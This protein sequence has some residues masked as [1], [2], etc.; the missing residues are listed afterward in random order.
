MY[1][2]MGLDDTDIRNRI[3]SIYPN[4]SN[5]EL[6]ILKRSNVIEYKSIQIMSS[7]G[8]IITE[9][10]QLTELNSSNLLKYDIL[11]IQGWNL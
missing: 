6:N 2:Y 10:N 3:C 11:Q 5:G 7:D 9:T 8:K 4:P 1:L